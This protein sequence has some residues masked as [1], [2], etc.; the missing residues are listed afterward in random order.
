MFTRALLPAAQSPTGPDGPAAEAT[1]DAM[2]TP[3]TDATQDRYIFMTETSLF[4][5]VPSLR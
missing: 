3:R 5:C 2:T 4:L 1:A